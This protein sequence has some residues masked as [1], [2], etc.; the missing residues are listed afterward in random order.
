MFNF[1]RGHMI[2]VNERCVLRMNVWNRLNPRIHVMLSFCLS[3]QVLD[4][5]ETSVENM[6]HQ[7]LHWKFVFQPKECREKGVDVNL[8]LQMVIVKFV[9]HP[10]ILLAGQND[11]FFIFVEKSRAADGTCLVKFVDGNDAAGMKRVK[12]WHDLVQFSSSTS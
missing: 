4:E 1:E 2:L 9:K 5:K 11:F 6:S 7:A 10:L 8:F 12:A 3:F